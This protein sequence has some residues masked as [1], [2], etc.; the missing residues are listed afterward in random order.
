MDRKA[1][2]WMLRGI[3]RNEVKKAIDKL[4]CGKAPGMDGVIA[5]ETVV[6]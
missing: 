6:E 1:F 4:K 5:E 3:Y 2:V